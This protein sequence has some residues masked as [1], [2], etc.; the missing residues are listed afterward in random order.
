MMRLTSKLKL[1]KAKLKEWSKVHF[2]R[3]SERTATAKDEL[4]R[5]QKEIQQRPLDIVLA[6]LEI[7]ATET[8]LEL[9]KQ[10]EASLFQ[11]AKQKN[12]LLGDGNNSHFHR[13]VQG[14]KS[15]NT[16]LSIT[17]L[18]GNHMTDVNSVNAAFLSYY[19]HP[20]AEEHQG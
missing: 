13:I 4:H 1:V 5:I 17:D 16:I 6:Q 7:D 8:F 3:L 19:H 14:R 2:S 10:E 15:R 20:L 11:K 18:Q 12:V 9:S